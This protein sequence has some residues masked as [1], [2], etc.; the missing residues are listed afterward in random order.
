MSITVSDFRTR[1]LRPGG[2]AT[3]LVIVALTLAVVAVGSVAAHQEAPNA[4]TSVPG[5][6]T[7]PDWMDGYGAMPTCPSSKVVVGAS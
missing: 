2:G 7:A 4:P 1:G 3:V 6:T 5:K